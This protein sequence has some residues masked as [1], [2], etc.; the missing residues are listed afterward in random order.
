M[1]HTVGA[2]ALVRRDAADPGDAAE[3]DPAG[4]SEWLALYDPVRDELALPQGEK[5]EGE[6]YRDCLTRVLRDLEG[7]DTG[8]DVLLSHAPRA[9]VQFA[10]DTPGPAAGAVTVLEFYLAEP[11][12]KGRSRIG[13]LEGEGTAVWLTAGDLLTGRAGTRRIAARQRDLMTRAGLM[14]PREG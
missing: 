10:E 6:S 2:I 5:G 9:H 7:L 11:F 13:E 8:K 3:A 4:R 1:P 14:P 12:R